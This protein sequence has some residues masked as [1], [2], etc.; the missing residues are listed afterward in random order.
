MDCHARHSINE[1]GLL[2]FKYDG[3]D[4]AWRCWRQYPCAIL[5]ADMGSDGICA[6]NA[7]ARKWDANFEYWPDIGHGCNCD[8]D[9]SLVHVGLKPFWVCMCVSW[10]MPFGKLKDTQENMH[11]LA[12]ALD[13]L[14]NNRTPETTPLFQDRLPGI[15]ACMR[16]NK[17]QLSGDQTLEQE[18]WDKLRERVFHS[19]DRMRAN[20]G[21]LCATLHTA[22]KKSPW[23]EVHEFERLWLAYSCD[24]LASKQV[25][26]NIP[27]KLGDGELVKEEGS[28][29]S[30]SVVTFHDR[31]EMKMCQNAIVSSAVLLRNSNHQRLVN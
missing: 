5:A 9:V 16:R 19:N 4:H 28:S 25:L 6:M 23:W 20:F 24:M 26:K 8:V 31:T 13:F 14:Y 27:M 2:F 3:E 30:A 21:R 11:Q 22:A 1:Q 17:V 18:V 15:V 10:N 12:E 29:T 7:L